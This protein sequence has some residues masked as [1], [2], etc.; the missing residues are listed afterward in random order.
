M[1]KSVLI[2]SLL[3]SACTTQPPVKSPMAYGWGAQD[4][5]PQAIAMTEALR[6]SGVKADVL[7]MDGMKYKHSVCRY[8]YPIGSKQAWLYDS[9]WGSIKAKSDGMDAMAMGDEWIGFAGVGAPVQSEWM[10][11]TFHAKTR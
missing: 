5:L 2:L 8:F 10:S 9:K 6:Q 3:V 11:P 1:K 7:V 4:C